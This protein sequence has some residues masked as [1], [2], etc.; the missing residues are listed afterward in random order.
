[1]T[2]RLLSLWLKSNQQNQT[3]PELIAALLPLL[4]TISP[5]A[6]AD[7]VPE[8]AIKENK[9]SEDA[10]KL[11][12]M[13][14]NLDITGCERLFNGGANII[15]R[16]ATI[17]E[18]SLS[19]NSGNSPARN[20][21]HL[22]IAPTLGAAW[23]LSRFGK[24][25]F[26]I[27]SKEKLRESLSKLPIRALRLSPLI[28][29]NLDDL[30][31]SYIDQ[32]LHL[33]RSSLLARFGPEVLERLDQ[34]LGRVE[35]PLV[36]TQPESIVRAEKIFLSPLL[37]QDSLE[38]SVEILLSRLVTRLSEK[39][40]KPSQLKLEVAAIDVPLFTKELFLAFPSGDSQHLWQLLKSYLE[41]VDIGRGIERITL[42]AYRTARIEHSS[43]EF[44]AGGFMPSGYSGKNFLLAAQGCGKLLDLLGEYLGPERIGRLTTHASHI[45]EL[46]YSMT[47]L[48]DSSSGE[49]TVAEH[50]RGWGE[51]A[52]QKTLQKTSGKSSGKTW[53]K[54]SPGDALCKE[55]PS[56]LFH[57]PLPIKVMALLPDNPPFWMKWRGNSYR[58]IQAQGPEVI[59][60]QW[61]GED[62]HLLTTREYFQVQLQ[63]KQ[64]PH[65]ELTPTTEANSSGVWLWVFRARETQQW[66]LHGVWA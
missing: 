55:R 46:T 1:M 31:V 60:P 59:A 36:T 19:T 10:L 3:T 5:L 7:V 49:A 45:P 25:R 40:E 15:R 21:L 20:S 33:P 32:L 11:L 14:I 9:K 8:W 64:A 16:I 48:K 4:Y 42:T 35:E 38:K 44:I 17:I 30:R 62:S 27:L 61:W 65:S 6:S 66:F 47:S 57:N 37:L 41:R 34:A 22:A 51:S 52:S 18:G 50:L 43:E 39:S 26:S 13:G 29:K 56:L 12:F 54:T 2:K 24:A 23:A 58:I 28:V 53:Q 63:A